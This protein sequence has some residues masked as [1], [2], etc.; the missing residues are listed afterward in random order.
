[1]GLEDLMIGK[2]KAFQTIPIVVVFDH[3]VHSYSPNE[4]AERI[5]EHIGK[6]ARLTQYNDKG[7]CSLMGS[8][9]KDGDYYLNQPG[10][11]PLDFAGHYINLSNCLTGAK[12][13]FTGQKVNYSVLEIDTSDAVGKIGFEP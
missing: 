2:G 13:Q 6:I 11:Y 9:M 7:S 8:L 3:S 5:E 10:L 1:M 12:D 4:V